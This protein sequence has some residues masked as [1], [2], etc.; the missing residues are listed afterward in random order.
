MKRIPTLAALTGGL[1]IAGAVVA[2]GIALAGEDRAPSPSP[3]FVTVDDSPRAQQA[4]G[5][6]G[7]RDCPGHGTEQGTNPGAPGEG[8]QSP[9][10]PAAPVSN[11]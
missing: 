11:L 8:A 5:G 1:V 6:T 2:G 9:E 7:E 10:A 4:Q 3:A